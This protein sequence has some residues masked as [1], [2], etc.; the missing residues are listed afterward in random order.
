MKY[1]LYI[2]IATILTDC[3]NGNSL[4]TLL[5][6]NKI[7]VEGHIKYAIERYET[8]SLSP[9]DF[10]DEEKEP[11]GN[12][13]SIKQNYYSTTIPYE[14]NICTTDYTDRS[15]KLHQ[16]Y[17]RGLNQEF[18]TIDFSKKGGTY[19]LIKVI[20]KEKNTF[21]IKKGSE[22]KKMNLEFILGEVEIN[23][24]GKTYKNLLQVKTINDIGIQY[25]ASFLIE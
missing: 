17:C 5:K 1:L 11:F 15:Q 2:C 8:Q 4:N 16:L 20:K 9:Q 6:T 12:E 24:R 7:D 21:F 19:K 3:N 25:D 14:I 18:N 22:T 10:L 13:V 23:L